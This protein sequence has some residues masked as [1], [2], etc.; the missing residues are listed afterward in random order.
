MI[1]QDTIF[2]DTQPS[3]VTMKTLVQKYF[4]PSSLS[5]YNSVTIDPITSQAD[6]TLA[7]SSR[8]NKPFRMGVHY[9]QYNNADFENEEVAAEEE[10]DSEFSN[11]SDIKKRGFDAMYL[12]HGFGAS[13]LSWLPV[14]PELT[15]QM[16]AKVA[17]GHDTVG[18][19]FTDRPTD[20][21]W[22]RPK[23]GA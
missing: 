8:D 5:K 14:L 23:Q 21:R 16:N 19:G 20:M 2:L 7:T 11:D 10:N 22:Y 15:K 17:L 12:Q 9:L 1:L 3:R 6:G 13:S 4:L 18:F